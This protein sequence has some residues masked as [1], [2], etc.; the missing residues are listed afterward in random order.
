M[1]SVH[2]GYDSNNQPYIHLNDHSPYNERFDGVWNQIRSADELGIKIV[3]MLGGAGGAYE[4]M[5]SN[6]CIEK[7]INQQLAKVCRIMD[8]EHKD[9][10]KLLPLMYVNLDYINTAFN[11]IDY[12][13]GGMDNYIRSGLGITNKE[14]QKLKNI[15]LHKN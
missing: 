11:T 15:L 10:F 5:F 13:Y 9:S 14:I 3:L 1:A 6:D 7:T 12:V 8:I 2:F 4:Y